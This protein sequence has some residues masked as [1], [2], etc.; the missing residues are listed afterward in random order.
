MQRWTQIPGLPFEKYAS[1][2]LLIDLRRNALG[3]ALSVTQK[4]SR[5]QPSNAAHIRFVIP[6]Q[7]PMP[8]ETCCLCALRDDRTKFKVRIACRSNSPSPS[9]DISRTLY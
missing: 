6:S 4:S 1:V 9:P 2:T 8:C 5:L 7:L 3:I